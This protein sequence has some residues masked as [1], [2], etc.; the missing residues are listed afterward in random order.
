MSGNHIGFTCYMVD[1][2]F[3]YVGFRVDCYRSQILKSWIVGSER[4]KCDA[5]W[6]GKTQI[7]TLLLPTI[8]RHDIGVIH[9]QV[10]YY[11]LHECGVCSKGLLEW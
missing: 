5:L 7:C 11:V 2:L 3:M 10:T 9:M 1:T 6:E 8:Y 4:G